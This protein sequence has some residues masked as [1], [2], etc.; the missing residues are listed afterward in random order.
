MDGMKYIVC[1][2]NGRIC[3]DRRI[4]IYL[5]FLILKMR[6]HVNMARIRT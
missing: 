5:A 6:R 3:E 2:Q 4:K 1:Y